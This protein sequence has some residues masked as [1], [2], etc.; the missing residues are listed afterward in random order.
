MKT[1]DLGK[2]GILEY[3]YA[4]VEMTYPTQFV[5]P[6]KLISTFMDV[7]AHAE[8]VEMPYN[9]PFELK[10]NKSLDITAKIVSKA[11]YQK[12]KTTALLLPDEDESNED[13][14]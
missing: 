6:G 2:E 7:M 14:S 12:A 1:P 11:A 13:D 5:I 4:L 9:K 3:K 10:L 8:R